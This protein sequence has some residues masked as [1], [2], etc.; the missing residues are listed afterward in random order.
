MTTDWERQRHRRS[1]ALTHT[2]NRDNG[3]CWICGHPG[4]NSIDH[5]LSQQARPDLVWEPTNWRAA[6]LHAAGLPLGCTTPG[7]DCIGNQRR[8]WH[9][10][11]PPSR[12]W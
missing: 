11:H 12:R 8:H 5:V 1:K 6:H 3:T 10:P 9:D 4:A 2:L 7:C